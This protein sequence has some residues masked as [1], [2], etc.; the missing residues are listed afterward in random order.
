MA[1]VT[2]YHKFGLKQQK[3]FFTVLE[4]RNSKLYHWAE[5]KPPIGLCSSGHPRGETLLCFLQVLVVASISQCMATSL[6][7]PRLAS[8]NLSALPSHHLLLCVCVCVCVQSFSASLEGHMIAF[9]AHP[10]NPE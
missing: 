9:R 7:S 2:N 6:R 3:Y 10:G 1:T 8:S 4:P 5:I